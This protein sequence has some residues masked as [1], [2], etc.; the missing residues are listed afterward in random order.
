MTH[1]IA[2]LD[3][4]PTDKLNNDFLYSNKSILLPYYL[5]SNGSGISSAYFAK[6]L[7]EIY[8]IE[9]DRV[10]NILSYISYHSNQLLSSNW[11]DLSDHP[12]AIHLLE[13]NLNKINWYNLSRNPNAI[14]LLEENQKKIYWNELSR[15][16]KAIS[17]LEKNQ[18]KIHWDMLSSNPNAISILENNI[19]KIDWYELSANPNAIHLLVSNPDKIDWR[20]LSMNPNAMHLL[21]ENK[22]KINWK[23]LSRNPNA[24]DLLKENQDKISW[25]DLISY[26]TSIFEYNYD[27]IKK[28]M[29]D[30]TIAEGIMINRFNPKYIHKWKYDWGFD[31]FPSENDFE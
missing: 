2:I 25:K 18:D 22:D 19:D 28:Y 27:K 7:N 8:C 9:E 12:N 16:E 3:W 17:I 26:N 30:S 6:N 13:K 5:I 20:M 29:K 10:Y 1:F 31:E 21:K 15:N 4:I 14:R 23:M 24:I 11:S